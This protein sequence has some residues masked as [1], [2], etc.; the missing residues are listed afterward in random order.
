MKKLETGDV[1]SQS[2]LKTDY[3]TLNIILKD[4]PFK[5]SYRAWDLKKVRDVIEIPYHDWTRIVYLHTKS[6]E[7][8]QIEEIYKKNL[9]P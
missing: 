1:R 5:N 2:Q 3:E 7:G 9:I 4:I 8:T 6:I